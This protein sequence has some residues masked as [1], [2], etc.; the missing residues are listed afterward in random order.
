MP[1]KTDSSTGN[2]NDDGQIQLSITRVPIDYSALTESVRSNRCG[3]VVLFL[4]TVREI[5]G[6]KKTA[7]LEYE[8]YEEMAMTELRRLIELARQKWPVEKV[9]L[10]HRVGH[11]DPGDIAIGIA[12]STPHRREGFEAARFLMDRIKETVPIW[13][14]ENWADGT[15]DW[16]HPE[17]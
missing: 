14:K 16:V 17:E 2:E 15:T 8:A 5:T 7:S 6:E 4:G 11:L 1:S 13:K 12:I 9:S 10:A 3:A